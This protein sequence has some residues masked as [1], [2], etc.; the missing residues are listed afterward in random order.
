MAKLLLTK[1]ELPLF[2][3]RESGTFRDCEKSSQNGKFKVLKI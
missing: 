2:Q 1:T 3:K